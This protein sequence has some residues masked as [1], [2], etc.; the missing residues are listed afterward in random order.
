MNPIVSLRRISCHSQLLVPIYILPT[1][2]P[3][4]AKSLSS[5]RTHFFVRVLN[6][7]DLPA[8]V[9]PTIPMVE[10]HF[11]FLASRWSLRVLS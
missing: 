8:L 6:N 7:E 4:V 9:Y 1:L 11:R 5:A 10:S 3:S 2:V